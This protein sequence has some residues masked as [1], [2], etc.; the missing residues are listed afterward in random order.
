MCVYIHIHMYTCTPV[1]ALSTS[2]R[3]LGRGLISIHTHLYICI[4]IHPHMFIHIYIHT[5]VYTYMYIYTYIYIYSNIYMYLCIQQMYTC[6]RAHR[7]PSPPWARVEALLG[8]PA[9][10]THK[11]ITH[12]Y[13]HICIYIHT[14]IYIQTCI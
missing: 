3:R 2:R 4:Y 11:H 6:Q 9:R 1:H 8:Q 7:Q 13:I 14:H 12:M 10:A 5:H